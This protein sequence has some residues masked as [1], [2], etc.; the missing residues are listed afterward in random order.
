MINDY[1][2]TCF[3]FDSSI[4][5][6]TLSSHFPKRS[7][8]LEEQLSKFLLQLTSAHAGMHTAPQ[9]EK[10]VMVDLD[11]AV[12]LR[13]MASGSFI[14]FTA[15]R[16]SRHSIPFSPEVVLLACLVWGKNTFAQM[17][18]YKMK[19]GSK[20]NCVQ[21]NSN[22]KPYTSPHPRLGTKILINGIRSDDSFHT[23]QVT[24]A[25]FFNWPFCD[26][27]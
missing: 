11:L 6:A 14:G 17:L 12:W 7:A 10:C 15:L 13:A 19:C 2:C 20:L 9:T 26:W 23:Y 16:D 4:L 22:S 21:W 8:A 25:F 27:K 3:L 24:N 18:I 5:K 1:L